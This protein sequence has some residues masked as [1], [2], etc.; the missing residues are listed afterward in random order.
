MD[1]IGAKQR[2]RA[3]LLTAIERNHAIALERKQK[4]RE[5]GG[6]LSE[7]D[8]QWIGHGD[9]RALPSLLKDPATEVL[10]MRGTQSR[11]GIISELSRHLTKDPSET[12]SPRRQFENAD[13]LI[14][15]ELADVIREAGPIAGKYLEKLQRTTSTKLLEE[16]VTL[17]NGIIDAAIAPLATP[18]DTSLAE[19]FYDVRRQLLADG[20][21]L[22]LLVEDFAV[23]AGVQRALLDAILREGKAG[24]KFEACTIRTA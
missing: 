3:E 11:P 7:L 10:F 24:G 16:A 6:E 2:I 12:N 17:F 23:L 5:T 13:F 4:V 1:D 22:V 15:N 8:Q 14:P 19:L 18:P 21:E 20:R 9:A